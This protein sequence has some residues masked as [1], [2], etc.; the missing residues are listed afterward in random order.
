MMYVTAGGARSSYRIE[1]RKEPPIKDQAQLQYGRAGL[2]PAQSV[3]YYSVDDGF[4]MTN[5]A[6][7]CYVSHITGVRNDLF[8]ASPSRFLGNSSPNFHVYWI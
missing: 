6:H 8:F 5:V 7:A 4:R 3:H 2:A 1:S